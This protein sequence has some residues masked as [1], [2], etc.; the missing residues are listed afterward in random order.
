MISSRTG[1]APKLSCGVDGKGV[2]WRFDG[3]ANLKRSLINEKKYFSLVGQAKMS[4]KTCGKHRMELWTSASEASSS[5]ILDQ[6]NI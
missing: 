2:E 1:V 3:V 4:Q 5:V 6:D